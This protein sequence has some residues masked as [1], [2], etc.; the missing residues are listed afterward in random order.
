MSIQRNVIVSCKEKVIVVPHLCAEKP[1]QSDRHFTVFKSNA[2]EDVGRFVIGDRIKT[3]FI[4]VDA[5][6]LFHIQLF[7]HLSDKIVSVIDCMQPSVPCIASLL[8][9]IRDSRPG[10]NAYSDHRKRDPVCFIKIV[11]ILE[12]SFLFGLR[13]HTVGNDNDVSFGNI[14]LAAECYAGILDRAYKRCSAVCLRQRSNR[15]S[16]PVFLRAAGQ[17]QNCVIIFV[18]R[19]EPDIIALCERIKTG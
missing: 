3:I 11:D 13:D 14:V 6:D 18:K 15:T 16:D 19:H 8:H 1:A 5:L 2:V 10:R 17:R 7:A 12:I 4:F 9:L